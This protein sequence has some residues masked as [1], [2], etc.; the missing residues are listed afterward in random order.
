MPLPHRLSAAPAPLGGGGRL[1]RR[2]ATGPCPAA[3]AP[4]VD[5]QGSRGQARRQ[6]PAAAPARH[7]DASPHAFSLAVH[8]PLEHQDPGDRRQGRAA[9]RTNP[10]RREPAAGGLGR[11][12]VAPPLPQGQLHWLPPAPR[13]LPVPGEVSLLRCPRPR[14]P[15]SDPSQGPSRDLLRSPD[16]SWA[17]CRQPPR[18]T[19]ASTA[20]RPSTFSRATPG[21]SAWMGRRPNTSSAIRGR[22]PR[23][24]TSIRSKRCW[25]IG[26]GGAGLS[27]SAQSTPFSAPPPSRESRPCF[28]RCTSGR[29]SASAVAAQRTR[30]PGPDHLPGSRGGP[31]L[32][33]P[34]RRPPR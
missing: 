28:T 2:A 17:T 19:S 1:H 34:R 21:C 3:P 13:I 16:R 18:T 10:A 6:A 9:R 24:T 25:S 29:R 4:V 8:Q 7:G 33:D 5:G 14:Q 32:R 26:K 12:R 11:G 30:R 31:V 20:S 23:T 15:A 27:R 22:T